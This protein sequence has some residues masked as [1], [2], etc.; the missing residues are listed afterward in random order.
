MRVAH[1]GERR[2]GTG[3]CAIEP[4][5]LVAE[6]LGCLTPV[7]KVELPCGMLG[8]LLIHPQN[9]TLDHSLERGLLFGVK[10]CDVGHGRAWRGSSFGFT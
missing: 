1:A 5:A 4:L 2:H 6:H 9:L 7:V 3:W 10:P 8:H